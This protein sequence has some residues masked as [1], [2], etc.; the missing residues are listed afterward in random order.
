MRA[1][2]T[3]PIIGW[4]FWRTDEEGILY[5]LTRRAGGHLT[6]WP[7]L[8]PAQASCRAG[9]DHLSPHRTC[10]CGWY[11]C[12]SVTDLVR[13]FAFAVSACYIHPWEIS[14]GTV[15]LW[16]RVIEHRGGWRAEFAYPQRIYAIKADFAPAVASAYRIDAHPLHAA[17]VPLLTA[18][19]T[20]IRALRFCL[21]DDL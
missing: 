10:R 8:R 12:R 21:D 19:R 18:V 11:A 20:T 1:T 5:S 4:R 2:L 7:Q 16:G 13:W 15:A 14:L 3:E 6:R 9:L 17:P